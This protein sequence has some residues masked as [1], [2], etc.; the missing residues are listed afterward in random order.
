MKFYGQFD[1]QVDKFIFERYF[2]NQR[3]PGV[4]VEC[5]AFDG[6][7][8]SSCKFFEEFLDW[9]RYNIEPVPWIFEKLQTNR[10]SSSN[11]NFALSDERG[12]AVFNAV[13][14][15]HFG[16]ECTNGSI[17]HTE[18]HRTNLEAQG[19]KFIR[20]EVQKETW[21]NFINVNQ[22]RH[23]DLLVLDVEGHEIEVLR[24]FAG[25]KT[26]PD[27][28]CIEFGHI[29]L[30]K[31]GEK[32]SHYGYVLDT[33]SFVNAYFVKRKL[34][35]KFKLRR[36]ANNLRKLSRNSSTDNRQQVFK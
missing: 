23:V 28:I 27:I 35:L 5:G 2:E 16:I 26:F 33:T 9:T 8:E 18:E 22:V 7:T 32:L 19:C 36:F 13:E 15:P 3:H 11:F 4:F 34:K 17:T 12:L 6:I 29:S 31:I 10:P 1:P 25:A 20:V 24:G 14:H 21:K 30:E